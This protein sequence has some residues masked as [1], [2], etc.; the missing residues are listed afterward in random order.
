[1]SRPPRPPRAVRL[2]RYAALAAAALMAGTL[3][4]A[5]PATA[6]P[7]GTGR[8]D[9]I[10]VEK[11]VAGRALG[12]KA[13]HA[14]GLPTGARRAANDDFPAAR[15]AV[16][17]LDAAPAT[18]VLSVAPDRLAPSRRLFSPA[19]RAHAVP[20][21][22]TPVSLSR[23]PGTGPGGAGPGR[24]G[25]RVHGTEQARA[26]G[27]DGLLL[28]LT[29]ASG[30]ASPVD[31][32]VDYSSF[33]ESFGGGYGQHLRLVSLPACALTTPQLPA[34]RETTELR[35]TNDTERHVLSATALRP[36]PA[37]APTVLAAVAAGGDSGG[38]GGDYAA[39][40]L[41][42][43]A[44]WQTSPQTG[45]FSWSYPLAPPTV[46]GG[47]VPKLALSYSSG[48]IDGQTSATNNQGSW[49]GAGF[50]MNTGFIERRYK[51]C[52]EDGTWSKDDAPGDLCWGYDNAT[53]SFNGHAGELIPTGSG[54][55][56]IRNDDGTRVERLKD[57]AATGNRDDDGE[58][59]KVTTTDGLQYFFGRNR[60]PGWTTGKPE[61]KSTWTVPVFGNNTGEPCNKATFATSWC[62]QAWRWNLDYVV[63]TNNNAMSYWYEPETNS[64]GRNR[65]AADDTPYERGGTLHHIEYG[66][67]SDTLLTAKATG[68]IDLT[69]AER[70][71][72]TA[73]GACAPAEIE[74][75]PTRWEDTP[76]YLNC[77]GGT[78]C[79]KGR[80]TPTFWTRK[81]LTKITTQILQPS[82]SYA[83]ADAWALSHAWGDADIDRSLLL[84]S[85]RH[86]GLSATTSLALPPV[87]FGY[88]QDP[89]RLD[90]LG[91]GIAPFIKYRL[92]NVSDEAGGALDVGYSAPDCSFDALPTPET[93]T[94]RCFPQYWQPPGAADPVRE[95]FN[96]Y[97]VTQVTATDRTG[98]A[99]DMVTRY[100]YLD[101]AA[102]HWADDDG[103]TKEKYKTWSQWNGYGHVVVE[104]GGWDGMRAKSEHWFLRGM[105][106]DRKGP[107]GGTKEVEL[108]DGAGGTLTDHEAH[109][110]FEYRTATYN[111]PDGAIES[112]TVNTPW[113]KET[114]KRVRDWGTVTA[115]LTGTG[116]TR[117]WERKQDGTYRQTSTATEFDAQGRATAVTDFGEP[118][119]GDESCTTTQYA[120]NT[121]AW[122]LALPKQVEV[123]DT[124][125]GTAVTPAH[126]LSRKRNT[127]DKL[128]FG[129]A[130]TKGLLTRQEELTGWNGSTPRYRT[131]DSGHDA[132]GRV[133][134]T[135]APGGGTTT[136]VHTPPTTTSPGNVKVT[137]PP[138]VA[139]NAATAQTVTTE[140]D[141]VRSLTT[142]TVDA[143]GK[144]SEVEYDALGRLTKAWLA[145][146][147]KASS[148]T[149]SLEYTYR[150]DEGKIAAVGAK[151][152]ANDG[153]QIL[154]YILYDGWLRP[155]Q[156]Q[157]A[158]PDGGRLID[159]T[160]YD[161]RG[162]VERVFA[163]YYATKAPE[164]TLF[165]VTARGD[166]D[167][168]TV[169]QY[170]GLGRTVVT[171][172]LQ[173]NGEGTELSRTTTS[174]AADV[175]TVDPP[176]GS[177]PTQTLLDASGNTTELREFKG[178]GPSGA[179]DSTTYGYDRAGH[180]TKVT[181]PDKT[182]RTYGYDLLGRQTSSTDPDSG[183][184][185]ITY[186][187]RDK[188]T[189]TTDLGRKKTIAFVYD[190]LGRHTETREGSTTGTL[191][192]SWTFDTVRKGYLTSSTR[193]V[194]GA[195]GAQYTRT[196]NAYDN[197][198]RP[199]RS[200]LSIPAAEPGLGGTTHQINTTYNLDGTLKSSSLPA[201]GSLPA[202]VVTPTYDS[203]QRLI[204]VEGLSPYLTGVTYTHTGKP[205]RLEL[206][207]GGKKTWVSN[208]Y[209][210]GTQR[211]ASSRTDREGVPGV[212]RDAQYAYDPSGN[213]TSVTDTSRAG[214]DRQCFR[215]DYL[216]RLTEAWT[217]QGDCSADPGTGALGGPA[218]YWHS[219][220][221]TVGG[222]RDKETIHNPA[223]GGP[224]ADTVRTHRYDE[225]GKN[226]PNTLTSVVSTGA[227]TGT[228]TYT[229][230]TAG[231]T[232][233]RAP[234]GQPAQ[235]LTWDTEG[236]LASVKGSGGTDEYL[237]DA[238]GMRLLRRQAGTTTLYLG[239]QEVTWTKATGKTTARR[240]YDLGGATAVR[241]DNGS[242]G[243]VVADHHG[244]G[245]LSVAADTQ[246]LTQRRSLP[247]G[248]IRGTTPASWPTDRGFVGG[249]QDA[250]GLTHLGAREYDPA[251]GRFVSG[252]PIMDPKDPQQLNGY[253]YGHNNPLRR[254]D[255]TGTYD[256]DERDWCNKNPSTCQGGRYKP[257]KP[258]TPTKPKKNPNPGM[259]KPRAHMPKV[260]NQRLK[261]IVEELYIREAVADKDVKGDGKTATALIEEL[262]E[263]KPFGGKG[264]KWHIE[265]A[266]AKLGGLRDLLEDDRKAKVK[267]GKGILSD[268]DRKVAI[269]NAKEL[270]TALNSDDVAGAVTKR[271]KDNPVIEKTMTN[272]VKTVI[273]AE[274]MSEVTGQKF[275]VPPNLH[276][277]AP[278]RAAP[279]GE[280]VKG[281][282]FAKGFGVVG[283]AAGLAQFPVDVYNHGLK[284]AG[285]RAAETLTD[286]LDM[287]PPGQGADCLFFGECYVVVEVA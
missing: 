161:E 72:D 220:S 3:L 235:T 214:T 107:A 7:T 285:K 46:P 164:A 121:T 152:L 97:V 9:V 254:S 84:T 138:A 184:T 96:K 175:I 41:S 22:G 223:G 43:S 286:P 26:A 35:D 16:V 270:W 221:Y 2:H 75:N 50:D 25:V 287:T 219:Y 233:T 255:P 36:G 10:D 157:S 229:Y 149:P 260:E 142:A 263:G 32:D 30:A 237:Y 48:S 240:S 128:A 275:A 60:L 277:K 34:C 210:P 201:A 156:S 103:L 278:Q 168:Q 171:R 59:W 239:S 100:S 12:V 224:G 5:P 135:T 77:T 187:D 130:P 158:G 124:A 160:F 52:S 207:T 167:T 49:I 269:D 159:D 179:Y 92:S 57:T 185:E 212:D 122:I 73:P 238:D 58:Y 186:D 202:E 195:N 192:A 189:T 87:T 132:F 86:T 222:N 6:L 147:P 232:G 40:P 281:R 120:D 191:L 53:I 273:A 134:S 94:T 163:P 204:G 218:R 188:V 226:Q 178:S 265:K 190:G 101:G 88:R 247:F 215:Y 243:F 174:Y 76:W 113:R 33:R 183:G 248:G 206:S 38:A 246:A 182:V 125:C 51:P 70:C 109:Q 203:L 279:S 199:L 20:A 150:M 276:P 234:A 117:A 78:T 29:R 13:R 176:A 56:R 91:D 42:S 251:L 19:A 146:R 155:R 119:S 108:S 1:M 17:D 131:A 284:E 241:Q 126:V 55:W 245:E 18:G 271:V 242:V 261:D 15:T 24:V 23:N 63:D 139:G 83:G 267:D 213:V 98:G 64:Y 62:R 227:V 282:G 136:T 166:V 39:T 177:T 200:T 65:V 259:D 230:D 151:K 154:S 69:S 208:S 162:L 106:G 137:S 228:D 249:T 148:P 115:N 110:G 196:V 104:T 205:L 99:D 71:L 153:S 180:I 129:A 257:T 102:W 225:N 61:T 81:R 198:Y 193:Y 280:A 140:Y 197:L 105:D 82:G 169:H 217:P 95:W 90:R 14:S 114:A 173:G 8:P 145:N 85:L 31:V 264:E 79:D 181:T 253:A 28:S 268:A 93:N 194:G 112:R 256:P 127:Y 262:N 283:G 258:S 231:N 272:L 66:Q 250:T 236:N 141:P 89:N 211:L 143:N 116:S 11:P 47:L 68:R 44:A 266:I 54:T 123:L 27:V 21:P 111:G 80:F 274:S 252:D 165:G 4:Q 37:K 74:K 172:S 170:D 118:A 209:E 133:T 67:R 45:D 244:T 216:Q 144:R